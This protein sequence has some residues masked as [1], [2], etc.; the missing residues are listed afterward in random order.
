MLIIFSY[1]TLYYLV[2]IQS[3]GRKANHSACLGEG[4]CV[5]D[6]IPDGH[7]KPKHVCRNSCQSAD[8][9]PIVQSPMEDVKRLIQQNKISLMS[10]NGDKLTVT[11]ARSGLRYVAITHVWA[12][13]L[14]EWNITNL[15]LTVSLT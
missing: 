7:F 13:G 2:H 8:L 9:C 3:R 11:E 5:G 10:W 4:N 6:S 12:E 15:D 1:N 14:D